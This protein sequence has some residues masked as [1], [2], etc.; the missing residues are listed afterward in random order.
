MEYPEEPTYK[1]ALEVLNRHAEEQVK[2]I[3]LVYIAADIINAKVE[4]ANL[5]VAKT[6]VESYAY[7][8]SIFSQYIYGT[9]MSQAQILES[10]GENNIRTGLLFD[11]VL[12]FLLETKEDDDGSFTHIT[13]TKK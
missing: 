5:T 1:E 2:E 4:D 7:T 10:Y 13:V 8:Q 6:E 9:N 11:K 3:M 12:S